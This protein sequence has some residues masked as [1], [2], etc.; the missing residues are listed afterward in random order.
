MTKQVIFCDQEGTVHAGLLL[1]DGYI[2]C[3][4]CGSLIEPDDYVLFHVYENWVDIEQEICGDDAFYLRKFQEKLDELS[5][6]DIEK[7]LETTD[8]TELLKSL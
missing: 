3:G 7:I 2:V 4:C 8:A 6:K 5:T 1:D